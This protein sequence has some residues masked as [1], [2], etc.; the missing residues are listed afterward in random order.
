VRGRE[1]DGHGGHDGE[2]GEGDEAEPVENHGR[3]FPVVL[4]GRRV[5][6]VPDLVRDD[7]QLLQDEVQLAVDAR[8]ERAD[9]RRRDRVA[10]GRRRHAEVVDGT[11]RSADD[12]GGQRGQSPAPEP[13]EG[14]RVTHA[15]P[16]IVE[17]PRRRRVGVR[18]V[19]WV[20][21]RVRQG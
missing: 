12:A 1:E 7:P 14:A 3:K 19:V 11:R 4:D 5:L 8:R 21:V 15:G 6:V 10:V 2:E 18:W 13:N 16:G 20:D 17:T 9:G